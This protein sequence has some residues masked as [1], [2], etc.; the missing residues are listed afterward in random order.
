[1]MHGQKYIK[2]S[3]VKN[4]IFTSL[5]MWHMGTGWYTSDLC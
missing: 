4:F 2:H 3:D 1:V 5:C